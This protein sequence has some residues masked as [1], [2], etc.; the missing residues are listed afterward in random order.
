MTRNPYLDDNLKPSLQK[1]M[2]V[3][4]DILGYSEMFDQSQQDGT[5]KELLQR[6]YKVMTNQM[7]LLRDVVLMPAE[8]Q[9]PLRLENV[10]QR[11]CK[12]E[13]FLERHL[14]A[15][16]A[17][18]DNIM[19][20]WPFLEEGP[21]DGESAWGLAFEKLADLQLQMVL[22]GFFIRGAL[23]VNEAFM[24]NNF[25]FG[26]AL[27]EA[28]ESESECARD[29]RIILTSSAVEAVRKYHNYYTKPEE[30]PFIRE[31]L[32][33]SDGQWFVNYLDPAIMYERGIVLFEDKF[34]RHKVV[35][36]E[37]LDEYKGKPAIWSKYAWVAGYHNYIYE[38]NKNCFEEDHK[39]NIEKFRGIP[40]P[41]F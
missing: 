22:E 3:Y 41:I 40:R 38:L 12:S 6:L 28:H 27:H 36:E 5:E 29:P 39:I 33:D 25:V 10:R 24:G 13:E 32:Q 19:I 23:S 15:I 9:E 34:R 21:F 17:F 30:S 2:F 4:L 18:T 11:P 31:V 8:S 20:G 16:K 26:K 1:S 35:V 37:R 7:T 14:N